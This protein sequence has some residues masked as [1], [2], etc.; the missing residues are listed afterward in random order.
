VNPRRL[1]AHP[2]SRYLLAGLLTILLC[3]VLIAWIAR[4]VHQRR[5]ELALE[6]C[7]NGP[8]GNT[9]GLLSETGCLWDV[10]AG[11]EVW[12]DR[13]RNGVRD[14]GEPPME[15]VCVIAYTSPIVPTEDQIARQCS[16]PQLLTAADGTWPRD[17]IYG[18]FAGATCPDVSF[19]VVPPHGYNL[20]TPESVTGCDASFGLAAA[21][22]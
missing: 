16:I 7:R 17:P 18:W 4:L 1:L 14:A 2:R 12:V 8:K 21:S 11:A 15:G 19:L 13:N 9:G 3:A 10:Q 5:E 6:A 20:T 22:Q